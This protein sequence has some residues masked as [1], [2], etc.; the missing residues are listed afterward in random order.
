MSNTL[1]MEVSKSTIGKPFQ[2][3]SLNLHLRLK[4]CFASITAST[5]TAKHC[6]YKMLVYIITHKRIML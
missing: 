3:F 5:N 4:L 1:A 6:T 2:T